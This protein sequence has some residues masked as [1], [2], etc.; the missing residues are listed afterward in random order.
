MSNHNEQSHGMIPYLHVAN[1]QASMDFYQLLGLKVVSVYGEENDPF[2]AKLEGS[3]GKIILCRASGEIDPRVQAAMLYR[4][5]NNVA[6]LREHLVANG[7]PSSGPYSGDHEDAFTPKG[8]VYGIQNPAHMP[9]GELRLHDPDGY[10][11]LVG[12]LEP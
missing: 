12:Q 11:I 10:V 1:V 6:A 2:W 5:S 9:A 7:I 3:E 8:R 4:Y